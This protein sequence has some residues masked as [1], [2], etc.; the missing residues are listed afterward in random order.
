MALTNST[1]LPLGTPAPPFALPDT[2]SGGPMTLPE[3]ADGRRGLLVMFICA[4]C[5][6]VIHVE[7]ELARLGRD[8]ASSDLGIVAISSNSVD[9]H[10]EDAPDK[11]KAMAG[12]LGFRFPYLYDESQAVAKA[13][14]AACTPDF[15]LFDGEQRLA[16][17]GRLDGSRPGNGVPVDGHDL[18]AAIDA[19]LAGNPAPTEQLP[20]AG[21]NIKWAQGNAPDYFA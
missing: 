10:P 20:S 6:F 14:T 3:V 7:E 21:C 8:Y 9:S 2:V 12:R 15:F 1:M 4:H 16:Y 18:R 19:V 11:L 17:R 5:P 13:Y